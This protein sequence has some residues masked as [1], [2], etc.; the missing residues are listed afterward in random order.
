MDVYEA[1]ASRR[2]VRKF[3]ASPVP[4][5]TLERVLS[6]ALRTPSGGNLQPW[7]VYVVSGARLED[8]KTRIRRRIAAGDRGDQLQVLPYPSTLP[9]VYAARLEDMGTRRYGAV[10][11]ER[12][13]TRGRSRVRAGNWECY[14]APVAAFCYVDAKM[15]LP[16]WMDV[17]AFLQ[18][19]ML[20]LR[21]EGVDSCAQIA[22]AEYRDTVREVVG[23][24]AGEVLACGLSIGY[25]DPD[26]PA[27]TMPRAEFHELVSFL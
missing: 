15:L 12:D 17:G 21:A 6:A 8:L 11:I 25:S 20:L 24:Q 2:S 14:G 16:Q 9:D 7:R 4:L 22:W 26:E 19:V 23:S 3:L 1:V 27:V 18:T 13:D 10:G 5:G